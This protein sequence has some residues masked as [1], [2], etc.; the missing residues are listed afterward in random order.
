M[1]GD[2]L[3]KERVLIAEG[4]KELRKWLARRVR[5]LGF[6]VHTVNTAS[7]CL[8]ALIAEPI[9]LVL[10]GVLLADENGLE[11]LQ[12]IRRAHFNVPVLVVTGG[13]SACAEAIALDSG[14]AGYCA[15]PRS[16]GSLD[17]LVLKHM[18]RHGPT[19]TSGS[20]SVRRREELRSCLA[21]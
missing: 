12:R 18:R 1:K 17:R 11:L 20:R 2:V 15:D 16:N 4:E 19:R 21:M 13:K 7:E 9:D 5:R 3:M 14:A 8:A 10:L 6:S